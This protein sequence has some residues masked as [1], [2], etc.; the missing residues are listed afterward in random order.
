MAKNITNHGTFS[1][2]YNRNFLKTTATLI[3]M[4]AKN[5]Y[6]VHQKFTTIHDGS[7]PQ[8][9]DESYFCGVYGDRDIK[10]VR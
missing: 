6:I 5:Y 8:V 3:Q 10:I 9:I 7:I 2:N 1:T 4:T